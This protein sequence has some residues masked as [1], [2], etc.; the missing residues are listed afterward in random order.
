MKRTF[1]RWF[2]TA[3]LIQILVGCSSE[4][5]EQG[6][7]VS[8]SDTATTLDTTTLPDVPADTA[9]NTITDTSTQT[10][11]DTPTDTLPD[12][13]PPTDADIQ[14]DCFFPDPDILPDILPDI[15]TQPASVCEAAPGGGSQTVAAPTLIATLGDR[16]HEAWQVRFVDQKPE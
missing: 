11:A 15:P 6:S 16:W 2:W 7:D 8:A 4:E 5:S 3:L 10:S 12:V 14:T 13:L 1:K 9:T